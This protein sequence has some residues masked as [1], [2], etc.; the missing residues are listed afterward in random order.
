MPILAYI[1]KEVEN[2]SSMIFIGLIIEKWIDRILQVHRWAIDHLGGTEYRYIECL[3][4]LQAIN[5][6]WL[7]TNQYELKSSLMLGRLKG[8]W[9]ETIASAW[10]LWCH[11]IFNTRPKSQACQIRG[12]FDLLIFIKCPD[13]NCTSISVRNS[14]PWTNCRNQEPLE[15]NINI[16]IKECS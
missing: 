7:I 11:P 15:Y 4:E 5:N 8:A 6:L 16:I 14:W 1:S 12:S 13:S 2:P 10:S 9:S 3:A